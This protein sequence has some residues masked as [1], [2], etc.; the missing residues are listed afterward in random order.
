MSVEPATAGEL[1]ANGG[2]DGDVAVSVRN[3]YKLFGGDEQ[4]ALEMAREGASREAVQETHGSV[5][6]LSDVSFDVKRGELFIVMGLSGCGKS[7][8]VR[9]INRL[10]E[11]TAGEVWLGDHEVTSLSASDLRQLRRT[12]LAMVFQHFGLM[13]HR[14]VLDNVCWGLEVNGV[15]RRRRRERAEEALTAVGLG[16]WGANMPDQLSGGMKQRVGLARALAL[17]APVL[18]MDEPFS[19]LDPVIRR[20]LQ[21]EL[22]ALQER[23]HKTIIFI[24]HDLSEAVRIGDRIAI[25]RDGAIVQLD[26]PTDVVLNPADAFVRD[27]TK[28]VRLQSMVTAESIMHELPRVVRGDRLAS[29]AL[30]DIVADDRV[31][32]MIVDGAGRY[33]GV[34]SG[35]RLRRAVRDGDPPVGDLPLTATDAVTGDTVLD[36]LVAHGL[37]AA[38]SIPVVDGDGMLVGEI[39]LEALAEAMTS[40]ESAGAN[41]ADDG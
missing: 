23:V 1:A 33:L 13:P 16:G 28:E 11:P 19:A 12:D 24:T 30:D 34:E 32:A 18:L 26:S 17:D 29:E 36:D 21:D 2:A 31:H 14:N 37:R 27:F 35:A 8:L 3:V 4:A 40:D 9:C 10:I 20:D 39:P 41:G 6:A 15:E 5:L 38:H 7:T 22:S 25:M